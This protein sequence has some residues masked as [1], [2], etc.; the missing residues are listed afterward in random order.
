MNYSNAFLRSKSYADSLNHGLANH[1]EFG[2]FLPPD[3]CYSIFARFFA[4][5]FGKEVPMDNTN[6]NIINMKGKTF[7]T[8]ETQI[9]FEINPETLQT[10][11]TV[12]ITKQFPGN[13]PNTY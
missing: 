3:P 10:L 8:S 1:L 11:N 9:T 2:T 12:D 13:M 4:R 6:I 7:A 5:Y